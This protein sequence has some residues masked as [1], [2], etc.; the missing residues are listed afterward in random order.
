MDKQ[1]AEVLID[2][3]WFPCIDGT[4]AQEERALYTDGGLIDPEGLPFDHNA[5]AWIIGHEPKTTVVLRVV[6]LS[7]G[8]AAESYG[9]GLLPV[10]FA[11]GGRMGGLRHELTMQATDLSIE[12]ERVVLTLEYRQGGPIRYEQRKE[13]VHA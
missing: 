10:I 7:P 9:V 13:T 12:D 3:K 2:G 11:P 8:E 4:I 5:G 1:T 6:G